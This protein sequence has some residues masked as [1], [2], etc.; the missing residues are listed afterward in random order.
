MRATREECGLTWPLLAAIGRVES[1]HGRYGGAVLHTDGLAAPA[2]IGIPLD[3]HGTARILDTDQGRL[4]NDR[5]YDRAVGPMQFIPSTWASYGIDGNGDAK[6]DPNNIFDAAL[7][8]AGYLCTAGG[9]LRGL[10]GQTQAVLTYNASDDY[11]ALVLKL[12][13]IYAREV[14]GLV[15]PTLPAGAAPGHPHAGLPPADPGSALGASHVGSSATHP[16]PTAPA[17]QSSDTT[18]PPIPTGGGSPSDTPSVSASPTPSATSDPPPTTTPTTTAAS[19]T[20]GST[21]PGTE[22]PLPTSEVSC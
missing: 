7:T 22:T 5:V 11:L 14:P 4:D 8:A 19:P 21:P 13:A 17:A 12:E 6:A 10:A 2:I 16:T 3:G 18:G 20:C 1:D 15:V 9:D